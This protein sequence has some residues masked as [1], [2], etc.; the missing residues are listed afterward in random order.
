ME[1]SFAIKL[2][3]EGLRVNHPTYGCF[4]YLVDFSF[5]S[6]L[7]IGLLLKC[8]PHRL[9]IASFFLRNSQI[10]QVPTLLHSFLAKFMK[11]LK[12][13]TH[14]RWVLQHLSNQ[15][16]VL[17]YTSQHISPQGERILSFNA[18]SLHVKYF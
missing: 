16:K 12:I 15:R 18:Q 10:T 6:P 17:T 11:I 5:K 1:V 2:G 3:N 9:P 4:S 7:D 13:T 8:L 14:L